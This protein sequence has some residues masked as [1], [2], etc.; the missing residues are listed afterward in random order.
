MK[1]REYISGAESDIAM[2]QLVIDRQD[3]ML[4]S[5]QIQAKMVKIAK[6]ES[7][8]AAQKWLILLAIA[9]LYGGSN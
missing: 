3:E 2:I 7:I 8:E 5:P 9:T 4:K 1:N 6:S